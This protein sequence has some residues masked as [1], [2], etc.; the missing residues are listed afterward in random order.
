M[1]VPY[2]RKS[3]FH[4]AQA[5]DVKAQATKP[6][7]LRQAKLRRTSLDLSPNALTATLSIPRNLRSVV[8]RFNYLNQS[9][10]K[11]QSI[12]RRGF[13]GDNIPIV[14]ELFVIFFLICA[15]A[16]RSQST[17][18]VVPARPSTGSSDRVGAL[19]D[20]IRRGKTN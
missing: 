5:E 7:D 11:I 17:L 4:G 2:R 12:E 6:P 14:R 9:D 16:V 3:S 18:Q 19:E 15:V 13:T 10:L 8:Q 1:D 20:E